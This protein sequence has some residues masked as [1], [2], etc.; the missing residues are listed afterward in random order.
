MGYSIEDDG[1]RRYKLTST[2]EI[3]SPVKGQDYIL[4]HVKSKLGFLASVHGRI[5]RPVEKQ[6]KPIKIINANGFMAPSK[7]YDDVATEMTM[8]GAE[9]AVFDTRHILT[10]KDLDDP[11]LVA[12]MGGHRMLQIMKDLSQQESEAAVVGHSMGGEVAARL[13]EYDDDIDYWVG[14]ATAGLEHE[15]MTDVHRENGKD[16]IFEE[17]LPIGNIAVNKVGIFKLAVEYLISIGM[18]PTLIPRQAYLLCTNSDITPYLKKGQDK[19]VMNA[20]IIHEFDAFFRRQ[21]Q[22]DEVEKNKG[23]YSVVRESKGTKH[24]H[25]NTHPDENAIIRLEVIREMQ[26]KKMAGRAVLATASGN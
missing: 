6:D 17:A 23:L 8:L 13:A 1:S 15:N 12:S 20:L 4:D 25:A 18:N 22:L 14:D 11:L 26:A 21:K 24:G 9:T 5:R 7:I 19:G 16:I 3:I 2:Q 10:C